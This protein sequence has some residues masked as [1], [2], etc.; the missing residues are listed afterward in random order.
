MTPLAWGGANRSPARI[1]GSRQLPSTACHALPPCCRPL[2][3]PGQ[4]S[5][6]GDGAQGPA[7]HGEPPP[8]ARTA[9]RCLLLTRRPQ[10]P[11]VISPGP[12][13]LSSA[14]SLLCLA[15]PHEDLVT[16][17]LLT[18]SLQHPFTPAL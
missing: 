12:R 7:A 13:L 5:H 16:P 1:A 18:L 17:L 6:E 14:L 10:G 11:A 8:R 15:V 2:P 3:G 4:P 9:L